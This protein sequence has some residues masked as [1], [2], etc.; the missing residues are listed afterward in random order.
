[1]GG[2]R[3]RTRK[4]A[5]ILARATELFGSRQEAKRWMERPAMALECRRPI[6]LMTTPAGVEIVEHLLQRLQYGVYT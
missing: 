5:E 4:F 1:M 6:D 2:N 3:G